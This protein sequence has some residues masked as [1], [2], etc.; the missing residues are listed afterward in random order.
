MSGESWLVVIRNRNGRTTK[1]RDMVQLRL[2]GVEQTE[3]VCGLG[4]RP[5]GEGDGWAGSSQR[6]A[7]D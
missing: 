6:V 4:W 5:Q 3:A 1:Q 2:Q 7:R